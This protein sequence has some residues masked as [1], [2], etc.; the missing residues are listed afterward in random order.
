M[1]NT[2]ILI[3][4]FLAVSFTGLGKEGMWLP[5]LISQ[6]ENEMQTMGMKLSA[7]DIYAANES[8]LKDAVV[9]FGGGCTGEVISSQGLVLTNH[10]CGYGRIQSHST[11]DHNYLQEGFWADTQADELKNPGLEVTFIVRMEDV[12]D[13][14][15]ALSTSDPAAFQQ[16]SEKLLKAATE[17]THYNAFIQPFYYGNQ[18][19]LFVTESFEDVRLVGAPPSSIGKFGFDTDNWMWPRHTGDFSLFRIYASPDGKPAPYHEDNVPYQ[20]KHH[21][22]I[23]L[24]G[25]DEGDFTMVYGF[26]GRTEEYVVSNHIDYVLNIGNPAKIAM[27]DISLDI[28]GKAMAKDELTSIQYAAKQSSISNAWKKW[29]G[30]SK[31]LREV[32]AIQQKHKLE[33]QFESALVNNNELKSKYGNVLPSLRTNYDSLAPYALARDMLIEVYYYG[34]EVLR[35][36]SGFEQLLDESLTE[37]QQAQIIT[38]LRKAT[39]GH[40]KNYQQLVDLELMAHMLPQYLNTVRQDLRSATLFDRFQDPHNYSAEVF[41]KSIFS[42]EERV[43]AY[44][45]NFKTKRASKISD[46]PIYKLSSALLNTYNERVREKYG[47]FKEQI[48]AQMSVYMEAQMEVLP[49]EQR[50]YPDANSTLRVSYG[51]VAGYEPR[52]GVVYDY[53]TTMEGIMQK[54]DT[55]TTEFDVPSKLVELYQTRDYGPYKDKNDRLR[56]CFIASNHTSGGN[57]GS[58][59]INGKGELIGLNFDR[60][61][62]STM[63]DYIFDENRCRNIMVDIRYVLFIVDKFAGANRLI[64]EM[65]LVKNDAPAPGA[66]ELH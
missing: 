34:P 33:F 44:L 46:D 1:K 43:N 64:E 9:H 54:M 21:L 41:D 5:M 58:P 24:N 12:T 52:D 25:Y 48:D 11:L 59:A 16:H 13:S 55:S 56:V 20:P 2:L 53:Y 30:Q 66:N 6:M 27:R 62:E 45:D 14:L 32:R 38:K 15:L 26:P 3:A 42:T 22:P 57:S 65:T 23:S 37:D 60:T 10:H 49:D 18:F 17:G 29:K 50:Y 61:W 7:E 51:K 40:F 8:S 31:G 63:S 28:I 36:A 39:K 19:I 35:F 47:T 4:G